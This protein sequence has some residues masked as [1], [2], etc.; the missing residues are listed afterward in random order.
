MVAEIFALDM[1]AMATF[2]QVN[3]TLNRLTVKLINQNF[4]PK[5]ENIDK[6]LKPAPIINKTLEEHPVF[7]IPIVIIGGNWWSINQKLKFENYNIL[8]I[9][10]CLTIRYE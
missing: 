1:M 3:K 8:N 6:P 9:K 4:V 2:A 5:D 7:N 10:E